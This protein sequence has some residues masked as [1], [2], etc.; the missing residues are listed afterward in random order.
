MNNMYK[1][2]GSC[3]KRLEHKETCPCRQQYLNR[4]SKENSNGFYTTRT[5]RKLREKVLK[6]DN[7][8]C[9]R[10]LIKFNLIETEY[11]QAHHIKSR[12]HFPQLQYDIDNLICVCRTCNLQ[13]GTTDKLDFEWENNDE[14]R[15]YIL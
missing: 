13:L 5:W 15:E 7:Y 6:R 11:L 4:K 8:M 9:Q 10:C 2:C 1:I 3:G 14:E 12:E